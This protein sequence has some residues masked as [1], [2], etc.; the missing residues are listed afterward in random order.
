M[1]FPSLKDL[2]GIDISLK[3]ILNKFGLIHIDNSPK[4]IYE[5]KEGGK[6]LQI[7]LGKMSAEEKGEFTTLIR[8]QAIPSDITLIETEAKKKTIGIKKGL[9]TTI[10]KELLEFY[11]NKLT[12]E[13]VDALEMALIIKKEMQI[14]P[15]L[16]KELK[17]DVTIK[18]PRF[19]ANLC[20]LV[21]QGY[22]HDHFKE[23]YENMSQEQDF[24]IKKY[25]SKIEQL[26]TSLPYTIFV[27]MYQPED[28]L[29]G[30]ILYKLDKL[31]IYGKHQLLVHALGTL[32]VKKAQ[33]VI[34]E[35]EESHGVKV[36]YDPKTSGYMTAILWLEE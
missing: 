32:N 9:P 19:G 22:F 5:V 25:T 8:E 18:Y 26:V 27:H 33:K 24:D 11:T 12:L 34:D 21:S 36:K 6:I 13:Y 31:K 30:T 1:A 14:D 29:S 20:N 7:N 10:D 15:I 28:E 35:L 3:D 2:I 4:T 23:L 17:Y 16:V